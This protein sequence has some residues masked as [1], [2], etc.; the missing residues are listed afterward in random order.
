MQHR[1]AAAVV[2]VVGVSVVSS[3]WPPLCDSWPPS[4]SIFTHVLQG[5]GTAVGE[6]L[7]AQ[8]LGEGGERRGG[9]V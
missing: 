5:A 8:H 9:E 6:L 4:S 7:C 2:G 3:A 1:A